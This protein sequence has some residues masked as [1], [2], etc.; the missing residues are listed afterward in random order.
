MQLEVNCNKIKHYTEKKLTFLK[1]LLEVIQT[2]GWGV[3]VIFVVFYIIKYKQH[4]Y[5][6]NNLN[7]K[8]DKSQEMRNEELNRR[9]DEVVSCQRD[10]VEVAAST[11]DLLQRVEQTLQRYEGYIITNRELAERVCRAINKCEDKK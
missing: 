3:A 10:T 5:E 6:I 1:E 2:G 11:R 7:Q 4:V 9:H 8:L